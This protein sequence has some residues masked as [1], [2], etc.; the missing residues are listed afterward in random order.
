MGECESTLLR[1]RF[2]KVC[3]AMFDE[4]SFIDAACTL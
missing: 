2:V 4:K 1:S 3:C